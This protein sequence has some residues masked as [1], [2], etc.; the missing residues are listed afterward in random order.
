MKSLPTSKLTNNSIHR[1]TDRFQCISYWI[2]AEFPWL[3]HFSS[4]QEWCIKDLLFSII[5][6]AETSPINPTETNEWLAP[7]LLPSALMVF[8]LIFLPCNRY[9]RPRHRTGRDNRF[10]PSRWSR[11][12]VYLSPCSPKPTFLSQESYWWMLRVFPWLKLLLVEYLRWICWNKNASISA[13]GDA[14]ICPNKLLRA[15]IHI[16]MGLL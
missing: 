2:E 10:P 6:P 9:F 13:S 15:Y 3:P 8:K 7:Y 1:S 4:L 11:G 12:V 5:S 16:L 14:H